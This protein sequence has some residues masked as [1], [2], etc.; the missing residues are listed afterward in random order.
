[1]Y[2]HAD[3]RYPMG[4]QNTTWEKA[5]RRWPRLQPTLR[6]LGRFL[7]AIVLIFYG[8]CF[9]FFLAIAALAN[10]AGSPMPPPTELRAYLGVTLCIAYSVAAV[11]FTLYRE[12]HPLRTEA[13]L[14]FLG[15]IVLIGLGIYYAVLI[16]FALTSNPNCVS[17]DSTL[18]RIWRRTL[19]LLGLSRGEPLAQVAPAADRAGPTSCTRACALR[20]NPAPGT[21]TLILRHRNVL[22]R[23]GCTFGTARVACARRSS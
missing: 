15:G 12:Q 23:A 21:P 1:M 22:R 11:V 19:S 13:H 14:Q 10:H 20:R 4:L 5:T 17:L 16:A 8:V 6:S 18:H 9:L 2:H 7:L 3:R